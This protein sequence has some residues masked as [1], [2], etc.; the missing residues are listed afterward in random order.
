VIKRARSV[1]GRIKRR[2]RPPGESGPVG[3]TPYRAE[4][5]RLLHRWVVETSGEQVSLDDFLAR[6]ERHLGTGETWS[7]S[8][9]QAD[10]WDLFR[11]GYQDR[12]LAGFYQA[13]ELFRL[14]RFIDYASDEPLIVEH[15][16]APYEH[17]YD[18]LGVESMRV[19]ELGAGLPHGLIRFHRDGA[20][21]VSSWTMVEI[22]AAYTRF[23]L[24][25]CRLQGIPAEWIPATAGSVSFE[26]PGSFD[27][28]YA[29]DVF[30]H[31]YEPEALLRKVCAATA[32]GAVLLLD[33]DDKGARVYEH[34]APILSPL[35]R[36]V[37]DLGW[38]IEGRL[39]N[40]TMYQRGITNR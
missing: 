10:L 14:L 30:E 7:A 19:L 2:L 13:G 35:Q 20:G 27:L 38:T 22:D 18:A 26:L 37:E 40:L 8:R 32:P 16:L 5:L 28:V 33:L 21:R 6:A 23:A 4:L 3:A 39:G 24:W 29:K 1:A 11:P 17:A 12:D 15:Y 34:V 9:Y 31:V 25:W 36:L